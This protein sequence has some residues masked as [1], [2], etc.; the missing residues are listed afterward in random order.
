[1]TTYTAEQTAAIALVQAQRW[2]QESRDAQAFLIQNPAVGMPATFG[3]GSDSYAMTVVAIE[4]FK[5][6]ARAGQVKAVFAAD[7]GRTPE[8]FV[9][10]KQG[11]LQKRDQYESRFY[12]S[13]SIGYARDYRDPSF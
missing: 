10:T 8:R 13:L 9:M 2:G 4:Y 1:M 11:R 5:T 7:E 6:G 12:G 3:I